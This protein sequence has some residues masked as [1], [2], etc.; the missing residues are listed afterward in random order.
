MKRA[1][2]TLGTML[3]DFPVQTGA[4]CPAEV[5]RLAALSWRRFVSPN[6]TGSY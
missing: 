1:E 6:Q 5:S 4:I 3:Q 2:L